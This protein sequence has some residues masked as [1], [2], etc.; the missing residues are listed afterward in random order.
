MGCELAKKKWTL[1]MNVWKASVHE[2]AEIEMREMQ[3]SMERLLAC[4]ES[5]IE[6]EDENGMCEVCQDLEAQGWTPEMI[7]ERVRATRKR[8]S[9]Q[10]GISVAYLL[11]P[12]FESMAQT[13][14]GI[15]D[16]SF[17]DM[18]YGFFFS[19]TPI[20]KDAICPR[21]HLPGCALIDTLPPQHRRRCT[22]Y[23]SWTWSYTLSL[24]RKTLLQWVSQ[25]DIE[26]SEIFLHVLL[27]QQSIQDSRPRS[28]ECQR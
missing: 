13:A 17:D 15:I 3:T 14:T 27:C 19:D 21:D 7:E 1:L 16:P 18:K 20:G 10:A 28:P 22:H 9:E 25:E 5:M 6:T 4:L 2:R 24:I 12:K 26:P 11:S 8:Q 23:L